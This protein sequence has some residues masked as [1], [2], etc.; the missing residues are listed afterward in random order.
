MT[1]PL[2][3][4]TA[5]EFFEH[6]NREQPLLFAF[7]GALFVMCLYNLFLYYTVLEKEYLY[8]FFYTAS[9][10][11]FQF[12]LNGFTYQFVTPNLVWFTN[13]LSPVSIGLSFLT[14][15]QFER[16]YLDF[17]K[18]APAAEP[19]TRAGMIGVASLT[20]F[21]LV[22][23]YATAIRLV[24]VS[25]VI[26]VTFIGA[27]AVYLMVRGNRPAKFFCLAWGLFILGAVFLFLRNLG[28]VPENFLTAWSIH[29]GA[30]IG[31]TLLSLGLA[32]K[33]NVMR[34][35]LTTLNTQLE[36]SVLDLGR[37]V[38]QAEEAGR[39][40]SNFLATVSHELR[41]PLN[42]IINIP[43][44]LLKDFP[45]KIVATC[46]R[47]KA[48]FVVDTTHVVD[49]TTACPKCDVRGA[50]SAKEGSIYTGSADRTATFLGY[51]ER[52]GQN[53]LEVVNAILDFSR[54]ET[55]R[56]D[57]A[58]ARFDGVMMLRDVVLS[59][60]ETAAPKHVSL[61]LDPLPEDA[62]VEA[63]PQ[64]IRQVL[65]HLVGNAI[66]FSEERGVVSLGV[67][68]DDDAC[69]FYV[70]DRGIG[71][72]AEDMDRIFRSF[73]QAH[74][75]DTRRYGGTGLGLAI[76]RSLVEAHG[77]RIWVESELGRGSTFS[78]RIPKRP[79]EARDDSSSKRASPA[80]A[81]RGRADPTP[82]GRLRG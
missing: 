54:I 70:K 76:A 79:R 72:A 42:A 6:Q 50:L 82:R 39:A 23:D 29:I 4:W 17:A 3:A 15:A 5:T 19:I 48:A 30:T 27:V 78:F 65:G 36:A 75:G 74:Q 18:N 44:G 14:G 49:D 56:T 13:H 7:F 38:S 68:G 37:A 57:L 31:L 62:F 16:V 58:I 61:V 81:T 24:V 9:Y 20:A 60:R 21:A 2:Y 77:G 71:I 45:T 28:F 22:G 11:L 8:Y 73:E 40:K 59:L 52:S 80:T 33:I 26:L 35:E 47:C 51:V 46:R 69:L 32:D 66:K 1:L 64:R 67:L 43:Q 10:G 12:T 34:D 55:G 63:D 41:T 25:S 53:L